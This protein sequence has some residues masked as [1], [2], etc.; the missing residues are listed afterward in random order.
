MPC[1]RPRPR[2]RLPAG[3]CGLR[4][5]LGAIIRRYRRGEAG[6]GEPIAPKVFA[7]RAGISRVALSRIENG[8]A[9]PR[10]GTLNRIMAILELDWPQVADV[11]VNAGPY[12]R[13]PNTDQDGRLANLCDALRWGRRRLG[14]TLAELARRSGVSASQLSRIERGQASRSAVFAWHPDDGHVVPEDR[15]IVFAHL[16]LAEIASGRYALE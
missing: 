5:D 7:A 10:S 1:E 6:A 11:G 8:K 16:L 13:T 9:C 2:M 3:F 4:A 12:P 14:W 15:R